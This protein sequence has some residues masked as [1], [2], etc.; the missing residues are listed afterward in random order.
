MDVNKFM[1]ECAK[2]VLGAELYN[3]QKYSINLLIEHKRLLLGSTTG[4]ENS[5][6]YKVSFVLIDWITLIIDLLSSLGSNNVHRCNSRFSKGI[7]LDE[8]L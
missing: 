5:L 2:N 4:S 7:K 3:H 1:T 8:F 6:V